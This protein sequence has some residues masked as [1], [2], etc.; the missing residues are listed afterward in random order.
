MMLESVGFRDIEVQHG[1]TNSHRD[2]P[3]AELIFIAKR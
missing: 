1:Y 3:E 2:N